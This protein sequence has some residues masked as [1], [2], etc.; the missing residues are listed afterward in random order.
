MNDSPK[1]SELIKLFNNDHCFLARY[2]MQIT[3]MKH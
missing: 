2:T 3:H 1:V